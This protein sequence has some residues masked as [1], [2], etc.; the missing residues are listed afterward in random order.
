LNWNNIGLGVGRNF[1]IISGANVGNYT[2]FSI[3]DIGTIL[4]LTPIGVVTKVSG[5]YTI[6]MKHF[7]TNVL[8]QT[9]TNEGFSIA[10]TG[11][12][13]LAY[14]IKRNIKYWY[15]YLATALI[16]SK[17]DI[18]N[19]FFKNFGDLETQLNTET[20][21]V[22]EKATILYNDLPNPIVEPITIKSKIVANYE[23]VLEYLEN[24]R[25]KKGFIRLYTPTGRV[26]KVFPKMFEYNLATNEANI[27]GE[28]KFETEYL[29][30]TYSNGILTVNDA[31]YDL[32]GVSNWW[33]FENDYIKLYDSKNIPLSN[34][35]KYNFVN[36]NGIVYN[37]KNELITALLA[38]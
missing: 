16:Y 27:D 24:Y 33:K 6:K 5:N 38:L 36:L 2:V 25:T 21:P 22:I 14:T 35:Y 26:L 32:S 9:R 7:Y 13:N 34:F 23:D 1:E 3:N 20:T 12:S 31:Q 10:P 19:S 37:S 29:M 15:Y 11:F 18:K 30:L 17:K 8:W 28:K 4:T